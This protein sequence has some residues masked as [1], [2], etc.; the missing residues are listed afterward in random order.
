MQ[1]TVATQYLEDALARFRWLKRLADGALIQVEDTEFFH[2]LDAEAN[3]I[4]VLVKHMA[5]NLRSRWTDFLTADGEKPDRRRDSE[6]IIEEGDTREAL[7][8]RWEA[9][10][11]ALF[12]AVETLTADDLT[13]P[14]HIRQERHT[15]PQAINRQLAHYG[16]HIG[17]I[18]LLA[19]H[20]RGARW[21]TLSIP[22]GQSETFNQTRRE[23]SDR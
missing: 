5:G 7:V 17:Q 21:Q 6:F 15:I 20:R 18:V 14:V 16:Y 12:E 10:W 1:D 3:S 8:A 23:K 2:A 4:A 9:G 22:R 13:R 19:K 11:G